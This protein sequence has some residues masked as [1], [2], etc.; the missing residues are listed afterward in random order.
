MLK[1]ESALCLLAVEKFRGRGKQGMIFM[2]FIKMV[3]N[4][5]IKNALQRVDFSLR[6][7]NI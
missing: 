2:N 6:S 1:R 3:Y 5:F 7:D 4:L